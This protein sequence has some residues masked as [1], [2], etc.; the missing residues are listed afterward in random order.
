MNARLDDF[1]G[2]HGSLSWSGDGELDADLRALGYVTGTKEGDAFAT[3]LPRA[4]DRLGDLARIQEAEEKIDAGKEL[5]RKSDASA[6]DLEHGA[7]LIEE[8]GALLRDVRRVNPR[9][10]RVSRLL[11]SA[12]F[13]LGRYSEAI[14]LL[15][16]AIEEGPELVT[17]HYR[18][19][20]CLE[21]VDRPRE[22]AR[23][24]RRAVELTPRFLEAWEWLIRHH[25]ER[26]ELGQAV[27][28]CGELLRRARPG[29]PVARSLVPRLEELTR[30]M[31]ALGQAVTPPEDLEAWTA[32]ED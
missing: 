32:A 20:V 12:E 7:A 11:A 22:A 13:F 3:G 6:E 29:S 15:R 19:A 16:H 10:P 2:R 9:D 25:E 4:R 14:P 18:L 5:R 21:A 27:W 1:L 28:W 8:G 17:N 31:R 24:M 30:R 26:G 23:E